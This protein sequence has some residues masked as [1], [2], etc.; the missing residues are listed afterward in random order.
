MEFWG[1]EVNSKEACKVTLKDGCVIHL[2]QA[3][4]SEV[5]KDGE[6]VMVHVK[7]GDQKLVLGVLSKTTPQ[8]S[9]DLVFETEFEISHNWKNGSVHLLGYNTQLGNDDDE[10]FSS[11]DDEEDLMDDRVSQLQFKGNAAAPANPQAAV[12]KAVANPVKADKSL[13]EVKDDSDEDDS[14]DDDDDDDEDDSDEDMMSK[15]DSG[16]D[17][18]DEDDDESEDEKPAKPE[19]GKKRPNADAKTPESKK[20]KVV[21]PQKTDGKKGAHTATPYPSKKGGNS[22]G[23]NKATPKSGGQGSHGSQKKNF[24]SGNRNFNKKGKHSGK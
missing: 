4:L 20:A 22:P 14:D 2:S 8:L 19:S 17:E 7:V 12:P 23:G 5:K 16:S 10:V 13:P 1:I 21:T 3:T 18:D 6:P 24:N 9:F 15:S 11:S